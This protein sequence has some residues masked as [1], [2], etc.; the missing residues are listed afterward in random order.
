MNN[1]INNITDGNNTINTNENK[2]ITNYN[3]FN[4]AFNTLTDLGNHET[5]IQNF[6]EMINDFNSLT[7]NGYL[8]VDS[9]RY[10]ILSSHIHTVQVA[11][12]KPQRGINDVCESYT[13]YKVYFDMSSGIKD[14]HQFSD[15]GSDSN[16]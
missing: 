4:A 3:N 2:A 16:V 10:Q 7:D 6:D 9:P 13:A 1:S 12:S 8:T 14:T 5:M 11:L 15:D